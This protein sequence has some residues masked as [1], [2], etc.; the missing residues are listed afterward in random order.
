MG[1]VEGFADLGIGFVRC[2]AEGDELPYVVPLGVESVES[3]FAD[4]GEYFRCHPFFEGFCLWLPR[5]KNQAVE[6]R[7]V[8]D[9]EIRIPHGS[10]II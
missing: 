5:S 1:E 4:A 7:F 9:A 10:T 8:D 6:A 2:G 3:G